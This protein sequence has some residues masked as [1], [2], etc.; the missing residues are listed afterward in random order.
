MASID[1]TVKG[2][3][4]LVRLAAAV[5]KA[6]D[7]ELRKELLR[8]LRTATKP[9]ISDLRDSARA[10]LPHTGGLNE[11]VASSKMAARNK[12]SG[13]GAGVR[14]VA[15]GTKVHDI[16]ATNAGRLRHPVYGNRRNW[17][18]QDIKPGWWEEGAKGSASRVRANLLGVMDDIAHKIT[19]SV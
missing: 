17:V 18:T 16:K 3:D 7:K 5:R 13:A 4:Q 11:V 19:R 10:N 2:A 9:M 14:V 15:T 6:G 12:T 1:V 8:G